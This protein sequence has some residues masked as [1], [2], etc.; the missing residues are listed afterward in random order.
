MNN[1]IIVQISEG[2][3]NQLFMYAHAYAL[4]KDL[5]RNLLIDDTTSYY[6]KKTSLRAHQK[7]I[8]NHF[9][10][11]NDL[12]PNNL[13]YD[14]S[15]KN[16]YK[17]ILLLIDKFKI[18]KKF[19]IEKKSSKNGKKII[20][21]YSFK[22]MKFDKN[23]YIIGNYENETYFSN[24]RSDLVNIFSPKIDYINLNHELISKLKNTNSVSIHVRRNRFSDQIGLSDNYYNNAKSDKFTDDIINYI[25]RSISYINEKVENPYYF[26]W[27]NNFENFNFIA[28]KINTKKYELVKDNAVINDFYLF[29]HAK[30]FIVGPSSFHWWGAWLNQNKNKLCLRPKNINQSNNKNF[31]PESWISV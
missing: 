24:F 10:I 6:K 31:W 3:G 8:L 26:I 21:N 25:N 7:F 5:N 14:T 27:S 18:K 13:K 2:L 9:N 30:H 4:S 23:L 29:G 20:E 11:P 15:T 12:A 19:L 22:K 28:N 1:N 16:I 17:K